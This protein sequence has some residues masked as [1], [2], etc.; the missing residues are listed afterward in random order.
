MHHIR[1][2]KIFTLLDAPPAGRIV[3]LPIPS[4]RAAG[5]T[6]LL[7]SFLI[8]AAARIV[9]ARRLF[10]F[11]TFLGSNTL[12]M[13]LN[14]PDDSEIFTLDLDE[15]SVPGLSQLPEDFQLTESHLVHR[16]ALDFAG[17][18]VERKIKVL[19]GN[20]A[21]FD[22]SPYRD[23]IDFAFIDGG[24]DFPTVKSDSENALKM[25]AKDR[26]SCIVWHDYR[27]WIYPELTCYLECLRQEHEMFHVE[28]TMLCIWFND[29]LCKRKDLVAES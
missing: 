29:L 14:S 10:E 12:N 6:T 15:H 27:N 8:L 28:D 21:Q 17:T 25:A 11:G 18:S 4:R 3:S 7:E 22:F 24:H 19:T 13:A 20:S 5:G 9:N 26:P 2:Y 1:P 16:S 23:S